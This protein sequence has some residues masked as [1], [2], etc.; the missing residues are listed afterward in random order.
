MANT[1]NNELYNKAVRKMRDIAVLLPVCRLLRVVKM[2]CTFQ[3]I[4]EWVTA[5][6]G[7]QE[8]QLVCERKDLV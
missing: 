2:Y 8:K 1:L 5:K 7:F 4:Q 6:K 3:N